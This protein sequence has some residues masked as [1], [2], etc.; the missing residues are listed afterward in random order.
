MS[1]FSSINVI[2]YP[3]P[4]QHAYIMPNIIA[5][6]GGSTFVQRNC[7]LDYI[8]YIDILLTCKQ[9]FDINSHDFTIKDEK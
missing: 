8:S 9:I 6:H 1:F 3:L 2:L 5:Y 4:L 7:F